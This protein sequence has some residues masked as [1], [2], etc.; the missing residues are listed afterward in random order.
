MAVPVTQTLDPSG[1][2]FQPAPSGGLD[3]FQSGELEAGIVPQ[4]RF[5]VFVEKLKQASSESPVGFM[6]DEEGA[7]IRAVSQWLT[8]QELAAGGREKMSPDEANRR[9]P[10]MTKPFTEPVY[11]EIAEVMRSDQEKREK[12]QAWIDRGPE[13]GWLADLGVGVATNLDPAV[14]ALNIAGGAAFR[15]AGVVGKNLVGKGAAS[16]AENLAGNVAA[17]GLTYSQ[18]SKEG[19]AEGLGGEAV[20]A[21]EGAVGG[22]LL[23]GALAGVAMGVGRA[24]DMRKLRAAVLQHEM[25][26]R[27]DVEPA[28]REGHLRASG[29]VRDGSSDYVYAPL[30]HPSERTFYAGSHAETGQIVDFA[31]LGEVGTHAVDHPDVANNLAS[32]PDTAFTG[33]MT[34]LTVPE[35]GSFLDIDQPVTAPESAAFLDAVQTRAGVKLE[36]PAEATL[37]D[38]LTLLRDQSVDKNGIPV[39]AGQEAVAVARE[40]GFDGYRYQG[41]TMEAPHNGMVLF[42]E[43]KATRGQEYQTNNDRVPRMTPD[44]QVV[45]SQRLEAPEHSRLYEPE[46]DQRIA[47]LKAE[48]VPMLEPEYLDEVLQEQVKQATT[49]LKDIAAEDPAV[50]AEVERLKHNKAGDAQRIQALKD[51]AICLLEGMV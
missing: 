41:G 24:L 28:V 44:E 33:T 23:H 29:A 1:T 14:A 10:G 40:M 50:A 49:E 21:L 30:R 43:A 4:G 48:P 25:G 18:R 26:A 34:E 35:G 15:A 45:E 17:Q 37:K 32:D 46:L 11:P 3:A 22:T 2:S 47:T 13:T 7:G 9:Y 31:G 6:P 5:E 8:S 38:A 42:D 12:R 19:T 36:L 20:Q 51:F 27:V 16:L 39:P